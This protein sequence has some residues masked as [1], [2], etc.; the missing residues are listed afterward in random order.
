M[1]VVD[2]DPLTRTQTLHDYDHSSKVTRIVEVQDCEAI[3]ER[4]K[5]LALMPE[6]Q[7]HGRKQDWFHIA[8][9]P[10][11]LLLK[12]LRE[13]NIDYRKREDWPKIEKKL[14][15]SEYKYLRTCNRI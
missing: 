10:N 11:S 15:S 3:I 12:W 2:Y 7:A 4:N 5:K 9:V 1:R 13:D 8:T 6:Y 14:R